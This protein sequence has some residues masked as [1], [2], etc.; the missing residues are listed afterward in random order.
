M[1][2]NSLS[3]QDLLDQIADTQQHFAGLMLERLP[4]VGRREHELYLAVLSKMVI[5]LEQP[6][7]S[8]RQI[9]QEMF[10]E[11][12]SMVMGEMGR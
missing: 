7:K 9:A 1:S 4:E 3:D 10:A 2:Q 6:G 12:A 11:V 8:M 5:K